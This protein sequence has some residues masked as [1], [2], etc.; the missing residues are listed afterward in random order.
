MKKGRNKSISGKFMGTVNKSWQERQMSLYLNKTL[1]YAQ[2]D[3]IKGE[4][5]CANCQVNVL[6]NQE[7]AG[8]VNS[9]GPM[10]YFEIVSKSG[11]KLT[12]GADAEWRRDK[13]IEVITAVRDGTWE[14][15]AEF[16]CSSGDNKKETPPD[17]L[18]DLMLWQSEQ[19][20]LCADCGA[21]HPT[22]ASVNS[23][24][25]ICTACR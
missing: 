17:V 13:W 25:T 16:V 11:E 6:K 22:W 5:D 21:A 7:E 19:N 24:T 20:P 12:M 9:N 23:G 3:V 2:K 15:E 14:K 8:G 18:E 4:F 1:V 10:W